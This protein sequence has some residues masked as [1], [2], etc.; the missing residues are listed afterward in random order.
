M[1]LEPYRVIAEWNNETQVWVARSDDI[2]G[3]ATEADNIDAL[4]EKLKVMVP[5]LL[6]ENETEPPLFEAWPCSIELPFVAERIDC[7]SRRT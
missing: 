5:K 1:E 6:E 4:L 7:Q 3:L 2:L